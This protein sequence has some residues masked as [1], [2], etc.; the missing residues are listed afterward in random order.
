MN[1]PT[2]KTSH[3]FVAAYEHFNKTLFAGQLPPCL[4]TL[5]RK[6]KAYGYFAGERF[7]SADDKEITDEIAMNPSHFKDRSTEEVLSTLAHEMAHLWQHHF[8]K[9]SRVGYHN[10][11]WAAKMREIGLMPSSTGEVGG[12]QIGQQMTHY[13]EQGGR[14]AAAC[15]ELIKGGFELPY[16][17]RWSEQGKKTRKA[18]SA[19]KTKFTC[20]MCGQ[21]AW[22]KPELNIVC[23]V[24]EASMQAEPRDD[25]A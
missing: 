13:I 18:K 12:K 15:A 16:V 20:V 23:G 14:Y 6:N 8:G 21:N 19:S 10:K 2:F 5:Q 11:E 7:G 17:E 1:N 22:G 9:R 3:S 4:I 24:C 25:D